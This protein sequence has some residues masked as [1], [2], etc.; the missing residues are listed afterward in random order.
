MP[1][2]EQNLL[3]HYLPELEAYRA[4]IVGGFIMYLKSI[5]GLDLLIR[6]IKNRYQ[7][8]TERLVPLLVEAKS[9]YD[10]L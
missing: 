9:T 6:T 2:I 1:Q 4:R 10:L 5:D 3:Y 7:S 8:I